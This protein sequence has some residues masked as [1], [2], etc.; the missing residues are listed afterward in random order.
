MK[1]I[2]KNNLIIGVLGCLLIPVVHASTPVWT[3][4]APDP[5]SV[6]VSSGRTAAVLYTV[7]NQSNKPKN[8]IMKPTAGLSAS[9]CYLPIKGSTCV[10]TLIVTGSAVPSGGIHT[11]P[12]LC[13]QGNP[14]QC[15]QPGP[16]KQLNINRT[17]QP[18]V[19]TYTVT[20]SGDGNETFTPN[21][22]Q[23]VNSGA[24][25]SFT[26]TA[27][28]GYILS[29]A[30]SGTCP[31]GSWS[32][33]VYTTGA[34]TSGDCTVSFS[35]SVLV[36]YTNIYVVT[37]GRLVT[38]S[39]NN[40]V[41]WGYMLSPQ[42]GW[43]GWDQETKATAVT[44]DERFYQATG[45]QGN[46]VPGDGAA[47]LIYSQDG[48]SWDEVANALPTAGN[49]DWAQSLFAVGTTVYV[50]TGNGYVYSTSN[51]GNTW[52]PNTPAQV[53]DAATV[54]AIVVDANSNYYAG[55]SNGLIYYSTD[56]G[57]SWTALINQP[58]GGAISS[59]AID[60]SGTL[61][62][63]TS[64]TTTQPQYNSAPLASGAWQLMLA[65]PAVYDNARTIAA[66]GT[67]IY[68]GTSNSYV[69]STSDLG[70][71]WSGNQ[72][73]NAPFGIA[74]LFVNQAAS[75]SPLFV[76]SYGTIRLTAS[77]DTSV[78]TVTNFSSTTAL[79]VTADI[80]QLPT[81]VVSSSCA[82]VVSGGSCAITLTAAGA[83]NPFAPTAFNVIDDSNNVVS[84]SA[85]VASLSPDVGSN[86]YYVYAVNGASAYV[87]DNT[88]VGSSVGWTPPLVVPTA[89][90]G[91]SEAST[92]LS[93]NPS[94]GQLMGQ[95]ACDGATD[96]LCD[97]RN[98]QIEY[99]GIPGSYAS[100]LC[101]QSTQGN[102]SLGDWYLP[103]ACELNGGI[104]LNTT[105]HNFSSCSPVPTSAFSLHGLG[106]LGGDLLPA[107]TGVLPCIRSIHR[108][109]RGSSSLTTVE[110]AS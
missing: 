2:T 85:L 1:R 18:P 57:Q 99:S 97:S 16:G 54:N 47:T 67:T 48:V 91:I 41:S 52:L 106:A 20:P 87:L 11:G 100:G 60:R 43:G 109:A 75:L 76:E 78:V 69:V 80:S 24:T 28:T 14:N 82:S 49:N 102:A 95:T 25:Q 74:S 40:G 33:S 29:N 104:Y 12:I 89:I 31:A 73:P 13:E 93:P 36:T 3:Y 110:V 108:T 8:L 51:R 34:I 15:Y 26:V 90:Y 96:G 46:G 22:V 101:Y 35:A 86:Y 72:V 59:L 37:N 88:N 39:P 79:N 21:T 65:L 32:G 71:S 77:S 58:S 83:I 98:I 55:T 105:T 6:T 103:S 63:I 56:S 107:S 50:G 10:L 84:R 7:T 64:S 81:G 17:N 42:G 9:S 61:Y 66:S 4:S 62:A 53:P 5:A 38:Y 45:V 19:T 68:V 27:N 70:Q 94:S 92:T 23:T 44:S 30:V